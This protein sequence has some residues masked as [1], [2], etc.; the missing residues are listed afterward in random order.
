M[1]ANTM[2]Q[3]TVTSI[4]GLIKSRNKPY[5]PVPAAVW[6]NPLY[7]IAFGFGSGTIPVAPG[8]FGTL[9]AIPFYLFLRELPL[10]YYL[11][12]VVLFI[13]FSSWLCDY[14]SRDI[15]VHDH[16]GM[17]I[18][19]FAGFFVTMIAA[20]HS[21]VWIVLGFCL[22]RIFDILKPWPINYLDKN[23]PGG[24]GMV[25]DDVAAGILAF[26]IMYIIRIGYIHV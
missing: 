25:I 12:F 2:V 13:A 14:V 7:F 4:S 5:T 17:C 23:V 19:E 1:E 15:H 22:F 26:V 11:I 8:T 16:P 9:L 18:D 24:F 6:Q 10:T 20:P 21:W 3:F